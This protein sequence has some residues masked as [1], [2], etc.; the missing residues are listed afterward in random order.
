MSKFKK[1]LLILFILVVT[2]GSFGFSV[3]QVK[4]QAAPSNDTMGTCK[5]KYTGTA[6]PPPPTIAPKPNISYG[7]CMANAATTFGSNTAVTFT[8]N[9]SS[10]AIPL[11]TATQNPQNSG[12]SSGYCTGELHVW[13][14]SAIICGAL[15]DL[16]M[17]PMIITS[18]ILWLGGVLLNWVLNY[19]VTN[20]TGNIKAIDG[21]NL[22]WSTIRDLLNIVF[23]FVLLYVAIG[24]ILGME[25][26]NWKKTL[27]SVVLAVIL[28]NFSMFFA[29]VVIDA[30]NVLTIGFYNQIVPSASVANGLS[31][32]IMKPLGLT[33]FFN[34]LAGSDLLKQMGS[35]SKT[36][37]VSLGSSVFFVITAFVFYAVSIMLIVRF[38]NIVF[39][40]ILSPI[41]VMG[42]VLPRLGEQSKKWWKLLIGQ[43]IFAPLFM[44]MIWVVLTIV[45]SPAFL[46]SGGNMTAI[47]TGLQSSAN[48]TLTTGGC[49]GGNMGLIMNY[50][51]II[52]FIIGALMISKDVSEQGG[53]AGEKIVGKALG[54]GAGSAGWVG[55]K[56]IGAYG[57]K[58]ADDEDL[59]ERA[60]N[61]D[62]KYSRLNQ[63]R[64]KAQLKVA[65]KAAAG[66]FD[67]RASRVA[68]FGESLGIKGLNI[69]G[70]AG[71]KGGYDAY[72]E[73]KAKA[74]AKFADSLKPSDVVIGEAKQ[75][76][77]NAKTPAERAE[78]QA[79]LDKLVGVSK[80]KMNERIDAEKK[81]EINKAGDE[82][83]AIV[84][85]GAAELAKAEG[86]SGLGEAKQ[87]EKELQDKIARTQEE[88]KTT[89]DPQ[90][91]DMLEE[92]LNAD[93]KTLEEQTKNREGIGSKLNE[94]VGQI[95]GDYS[96]KLRG[97]DEQT[98]KIN[99]KYDKRKSDNTEG[100][101][102]A[103]EQ[104]KR[105]YAN[106][107]T[108]TSRA[109]VLKRIDAE[110]DGEI[111][112]ATKEDRSELDGAKQK[113]GELRKEATRR[114]EEI[115]RTTLPL[116]KA[117][118]EAE[119]RVVKENLQKQVELV[120][121]A[122]KRMSEKVETITKKYE[123]RREN[124]SE[125]PG[126]GAFSTHRV[127]LVGPLKHSS[128]VAVARMRGTGG[129][130][131]AEKLVA[132]YGK[133]LAEQKKRGEIKEE[134]AEEETGKTEPAAPTAPT[135][136]APATPPETS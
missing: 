64:A 43:A 113:E 106:T 41:S 110:R 108:G 22:A 36:A 88:M 103:G 28:I 8:P 85:E 128:K 72:D 116:I 27:I 56:T 63:I 15:S 57:R 80:N 4:A 107:I 14:G 136:P 10:S 97:A 105:D 134:E 38:V 123:N 7:N 71:G 94:R 112:K 18:W 70:K 51:I 20:L 25:K 100:Q 76:V 6:N 114:Q 99:V 45:N 37:I 3:P 69:A 54:F 48:G 115:N 87:K 30:S 120:V 2:V 11:N 119:L 83:N 81:A 47:F 46:C 86:E 82:K 17:I 61:V 132:Q 21:I 98:D 131:E 90:G 102:S 89:L 31:N 29:E 66:S 16:L 78:A 1:I 67:T 77:A 50:I 44:I 42:S 84:A 24:T 39:L 60:A 74:K 75:A 121:Q 32:A 126:P 58:T 122:Q 104:R 19:T 101:L 65:Q 124:A 55:R 79:K 127:L 62:G 53:S 117:Q 135:P 130:S 12:I 23:I 96:E 118:K 109:E 73:E 33:T 95:T 13:T 92:Q 68:G 35:L 93:R 133:V 26:V 5:Y 129:K 91:A 9:G 111:S 125:I 49:A 59:K 40:L 52:S 34:P